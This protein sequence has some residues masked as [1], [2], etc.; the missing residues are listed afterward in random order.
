MKAEARFVEGDW[1]QKCLAA[2][3]SD[4]YTVYA[5]GRDGDVT[6]FMRCDSADAMALDVINTKYPIK[7]V[8]FPMTETLMEYRLSKTEGETC[9][10]P[11]A[12]LKQL[13]VLGC[14]PCD[15]A[16]LGVLD[17]VFNWDYEDVPFNTRR[18]NSLIMTVGCAQSDE[19]CFCTTLGHG[20]DGTDGSDWLIQEI[21]DR[22]A[23]VIPCSE[24]GQAFAEAHKDILTDVPE[25]AEAPVADVPVNVDLEKV[26][27]WLDAHFEDALW[28]DIALACLGCGACSYL[29]PTCHCFDIVDEGNW[30]GGER[31]RNYDCCSYALFTKH[32][33]GHNPRPGQVSRCRNRLMHKFKYFVERFDRRACVGCG[34]CTRQC[35]VGRSLVSMLQQIT[36]KAD[37]EAAAEASS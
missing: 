26:K 4:G 30:Q 33:S 20:P 31:R 25:G 21:P 5:P 11:S 15:A 17:Q 23:R 22:G 12:E 9:E 8:F 19:Q 6:R 3:K 13:A 10:T 24:K 14:R 16:S 37:A 32:T 36:S 28:E 7:E 29:C 1:R 18:K 34:R 35:G 27:P 2:L